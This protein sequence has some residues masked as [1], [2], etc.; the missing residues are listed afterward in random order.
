MTTT[1]RKSRAKKRP[2]NLTHQ[3]QAEQLEEV[4]QSP[5]TIWHTEVA[6]AFLGVSAET[7]R[8]WRRFGG[9]PPYVEISPNR[10]GY[11]KVDMEAWTASHLRQST[12]E[13]RAETSSTSSPSAGSKS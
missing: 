12:S 1:A 6:A 11:R 8:K 3:L 2:P 9:G 7:L 5:S 4:R 13:E 10:V